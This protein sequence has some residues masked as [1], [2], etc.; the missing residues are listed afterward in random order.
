MKK[1]IISALIFV[2]LI[3]Y[4]AFSAGGFISG[5]K[6]LGEIINIFGTVF[7]LIFNSFLSIPDVAQEIIKSILTTVLVWA[8]YGFGLHGAEK[9]L[10]WGIAGAFA[11][12]I[13]TILAWI[14]MI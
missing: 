11:S 1:I 3:L 6:V 12:L 10:V 8:I 5:M 7:V 13:C 14:G 2:G 4:C 9:K